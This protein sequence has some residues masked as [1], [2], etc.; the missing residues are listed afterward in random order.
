VVD[1]GKKLKITNDIIDESWQPVLA[2]KKIREV[3]MVHTFDLYLKKCHI[4]HVLCRV[5][6]PQ[7]KSMLE[8]FMIFT[9]IIDYGLRV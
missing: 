4:R 1:A 6:H 7:T 2:N 8:K 3:M 5:G 9:L